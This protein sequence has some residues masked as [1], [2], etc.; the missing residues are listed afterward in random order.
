MMALPHL[1]KGS[2]YVAD[3]AESS[4]LYVPTL[5]QYLNGSWVVFVYRL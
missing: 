4:L 3:V 2:L 5:A 1:S